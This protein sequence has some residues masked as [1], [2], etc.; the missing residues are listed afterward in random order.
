LAV[1]RNLT[2]LL[3]KNTVALVSGQQQYA[4]I[5]QMTLGQHDAKTFQLFD[6]LAGGL[7]EL[8]AAADVVVARAGATTLAELMTLKKAAIIVP[9]E[10]LTGGHQTKNAAIL[11]KAGAV[12][13][14]GSE[15]LE[16]ELVDKVDDI[17]RNQKLKSELEAN[18]ASFAQESATSDLAMVVLRAAKY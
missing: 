18:L 16:A 12:M 10:F 9:N 8:L 7:G 4:E 14:V 13:V 15:K 6:F 17:M 11:E 5:K 1:A 2:K 3:E